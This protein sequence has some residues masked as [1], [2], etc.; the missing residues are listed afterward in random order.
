MDP[1]RAQFARKIIKDVGLSDKIE[2]INENF[3][4]TDIKADVFVSETI[5]SQ[6]FNEYIIDISKHALRYGGTFIPSKFNLWIEV[7]DDH[8]IF[9]LVMNDSAAF[10][11]QPDIEIDPTFEK[12]IN[13]GFQAQHPLDTTLYRATTIN[14]LFTMLPRF[15]DLKLKKLYQTEKVTID[16]TQPIDQNNIKVMIPKEKFY[17][18]HTQ[19]MVLFWDCEMFGDIVMPVKETWWGNPAKVILPHVR[20]HDIDMGMS[21]DPVSTQWRVHF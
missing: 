16:L 8:P 1:G 20:N 7:Y 12:L 3:Y 21:Y 18:E 11:F 13:D 6:I 15:T 14:G 19:V 10:E 9:P 17:H 5:G 4:N 2:V